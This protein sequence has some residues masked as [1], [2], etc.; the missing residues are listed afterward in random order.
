MA[1]GRKKK[2]APPEV[3]PQGDFDWAEL[4]R[5]GNAEI[6]AQHDQMFL[7]ADAL[8]ESLVDAAAGGVTRDPLELLRAFI[9]ATYRHFRFEEELMWSEGYPWSEAH[10]QEHGALL[11]RIGEHSY[12]FEVGQRNVAQIS[13][14]LRVWIS[15]HI[16]ETDRELVVWLASRELPRSE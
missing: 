13:E 7:L 4:I 15:R 2:K 5:L 3:S 9:D 8:V 16:D 6:D 10:A 1:F 12:M 11:K 14:F